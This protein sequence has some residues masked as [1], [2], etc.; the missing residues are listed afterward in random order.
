MTWKGVFVRI[1]NSLRINSFD[2]NIWEHNNVLLQLQA[3]LKYRDLTAMWKDG[4]VVNPE[5]TPTPS[6]GFPCKP[7]IPATSFEVN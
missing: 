3:E 2:N 6:R 5:T 4:L 7:I 1:I